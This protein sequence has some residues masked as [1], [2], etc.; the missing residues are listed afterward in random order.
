MRRIQVALEIG[1]K[2]TFAAALEWPG[3][4]RSGRDERGALSALLEYG[5]RFAAVLG[6]VGG[7]VPPTDLAGLEVAER[8]PGSASTEF[9]APG[10][11]PLADAAPAGPAD[12]ERLAAV[13]AACWA[14]FDRA[15]TAAEGVELRKGPRGGGRDLA[16]IRAH[17]LESDRAY[18][19]QLGGRSGKDSTHAEV[20]DAFVEALGARARGELPD[21]GPR[22]GSRWSARFAARYAAWHTLDHA[23]EIED[24]S[25]G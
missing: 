15:A 3:W 22:G 6:G 1:H 21:A 25:G 19:S 20:R 12:V 14:A 2:R 13:L 10:T 11:P 7:F 8:L 17:V 23:W 4:C 16:R 5:P 24:R 9:G 18:L